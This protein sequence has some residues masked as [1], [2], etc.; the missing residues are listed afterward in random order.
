MASLKFPRKP[1]QM[2]ENFSFFPVAS[3]EKKLSADVRI[4]TCS[5]DNPPHRILR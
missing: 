1:D 2:T 5:C 3:G 4:V